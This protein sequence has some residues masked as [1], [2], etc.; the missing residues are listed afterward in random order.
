MP[1]KKYNIM[2][3]DKENPL[4]GGYASG[5]GKK[6]CK[7]CV[8]KFRKKKNLNKLSKKC[9]KGKKTKKYAKKKCKG[10]KGKKKRQNCRRKM[11]VLRCAK[12]IKE[13]KKKCKKKSTKKSTKSDS[14][15]NSNT[16]SNSQVSSLVDDI[17][18]D[19]II[20]DTNLGL[21]DEIVEEIQEIPEERKF[22]CGQDRPL[23][24][25][26]KSCSQIDDPCVCG[27]VTDPKLNN[28]HRCRWTMDKCLDFPP[29]N[30]SNYKLTEEGRSIARCPTSGD[31]AKVKSKNSR[32]RDGPKSCKNLKEFKTLKDPSNPDGE[33][34]L[35][36]QCMEG[37]S[38][39]NAGCNDY[40]MLKEWYPSRDDHWK[41]VPKLKAARRSEK[42]RHSYFDNRG[43]PGKK[44]LELFG[45]EP[46]DY[47][48]PSGGKLEDYVKQGDGSP[49]CQGCFM[50]HIRPVDKDGFELYLKEKDKYLKEME[51]A[52]DKLVEMEQ[53][54]DQ[55]KDH[56]DAI[57]QAVANNHAHV[58]NHENNVSKLRNKMKA[59]NQTEPTSTDQIVLDA[60]KEE[61]S[62]ES[63]L[64]ANLIKQEIA[65]DKLEANIRNWKMKTLIAGT[66]GVADKRWHKR[67]AY[68]KKQADLVSA[69]A[70]KKIQERFEIAEKLRKQK[71]S[72]EED[73]V[74]KIEELEKELDHK[75][76]AV[77]V[78]TKDE[79]F[80]SAQ[81]NVE[82]H[83]ATEENS[84]DVKA[85]EELLEE[86]RTSI[87]CSDL[88]SRGQCKKHDHCKWYI[89]RNKSKHSKGRVLEPPKCIHKE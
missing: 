72:T 65:E 39:K 53:K 73:S 32:N 67:L 83:L 81:F 79:E 38:W 87:S 80:T 64:E 75:D 25:L 26:S 50:L 77:L 14:G 3:D 17:M 5:G 46:S 29:S 21:N 57:D 42:F 44:A 22:M 23:S 24:E 59:N 54:L 4:F 63:K 49:G 68:K 74:I 27:F 31:Y 6:S 48:G 86:V 85:A 76:E 12:R 28:R 45:K 51:K 10:T 1:L 33:D 20:E 70:R 9:L 13:C 66:F 37:I 18:N 40:E 56:T 2:N 55:L 60:A 71:L 84:D 69:A 36:K 8:K 61:M 58:E 35:Q 11:S 7:K 43:M 47:V 62:R 30:I 88:S 78:A 52:T 19:P 16:M 34:A 82:F 41:L 15:I 89:K